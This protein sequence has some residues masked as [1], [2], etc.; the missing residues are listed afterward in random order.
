MNFIT[1]F[2]NIGS[3][4][5]FWEYFSCRKT[6]IL[7]LDYSFFLDWWSLIVWSICVALIVLMTVEKYVKVIFFK[8]RQKVFNYRC[9]I[10][11]VQAKYWMVHYTGFPNNFIIFWLGFQSIF[12]PFH[13]FISLLPKTL[14]LALRIVKML[15]L[16][17]EWKNSFVVFA[18][19]FTQ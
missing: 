3:L 2:G 4:F 16:F 12:Y 1:F 17:T 6:C 5:S 19:C 18:N 9:E 8:K 11:I 14:V 13:H 7:S 10:R 15:V